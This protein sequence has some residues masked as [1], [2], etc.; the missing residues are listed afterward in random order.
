M[1]RLGLRSS[2]FAEKTD[3]EMSAFV[4]PKY[5]IVW[6][7]ILWWL[8]NRT[9]FYIRAARTIT[10]FLEWLIRETSGLFENA[11]I[12]ISVAIRSTDFVKLDITCMRTDIIAT[13]IAT[14]SFR[15]QNQRNDSHFLWFEK[16]KLQ[17]WI[18]L[19]S[20]LFADLSKYHTIL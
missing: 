19:A 18:T 16:L 11:K 9:A 4:M 13:Q 14:E 15:N 20:P 12:D 3:H 2:R 10:N 8:V 7:F 5:A 6:I 1:S 17:E